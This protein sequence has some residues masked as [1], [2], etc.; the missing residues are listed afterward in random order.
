MKDNHCH[1]MII[2]HDFEDHFLRKKSANDDSSKLFVSMS[3]T[4]RTWV[5]H[6]LQGKPNPIST[7][8]LKDFLYGSKLMS[9]GSMIYLY[10]WMIEEHQLIGIYYHLI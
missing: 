3:P 1:D 6:V 7:R 2:L 8:T 5:P 9:Y 10:G 4:I